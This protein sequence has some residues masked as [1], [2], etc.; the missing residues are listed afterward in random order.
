MAQAGHPSRTGVTAIG[1]AVDAY[2]TA[3]ATTRT[4]VA[5]GL[6]DG[7]VRLV[8]LD[9][10]NTM[11]TVQSHA[12]AT[13]TVVTDIDGETFLSG[14]DDGRLLRIPAGGEPEELGRWQ[15]K[16]LETVAVHAST[17]LRAI[18]VGKEV[19]LLRP[20]GSLLQ[21][22]GH[23]STA[24]GA[25]FD[26]GGGR[27]AVSRYG[28]VTLWLSYK[29]GWRSTP[30][31][32]AG[33]H[34]MVTWSPN[35]KFIVSAMQENALH[36]WRLADKK[37]MRM[38][39]YPAKVRSWSWAANGRWLATSGA[40]SAVLWPFR[41]ADGPMGKEP[42]TI[43][44]GEEFVTTVAAHPTEPLV[45]LG[46][47]H[48]SVRLVRIPTEDSVTLRPPDG[49]PISALGWTTD[50]RTLLFGTEAGG[51]YLLPLPR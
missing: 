30:L 36:G 20:D 21:T 41:T 7:T 39:G 26:A 22:L 5:F 43:G 28:G 27:L 19:L 35:S 38:R 23:E 12:G 10:P 48:G 8:G 46:G 14:G 32:W 49:D 16:W 17:R 3:I 4:T 2:V 9:A 25:A 18:A 33:A 13:L 15:G 44:A 50:G 51:A 6:G 24:T 11:R 1:H 40:A 42:L 47:K 34:S 45:A 29:D 31:P 37:T